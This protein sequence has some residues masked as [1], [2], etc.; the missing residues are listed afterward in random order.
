MPIVDVAAVAVDIVVVFV[1]G[2]TV[3]AF[4]VVDNATFVSL[5]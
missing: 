4:A 3:V 1:A 2:I 5:L